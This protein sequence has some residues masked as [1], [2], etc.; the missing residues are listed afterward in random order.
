MVNKN[1]NTDTWKELGI[2]NP[3]EKL[4]YH[5]QKCKDYLNRMEHAVTKRNYDDV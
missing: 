4:E 2:F 3:Y 5:K 1:G